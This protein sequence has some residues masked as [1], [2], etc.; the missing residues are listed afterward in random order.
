MYRMQRPLRTALAAIG[1]F[2]NAQ[3]GT[4]RASG[5]FVNAQNGTRRASGR[6]V[7]AQSVMR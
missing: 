7:K 4:R 1:R 2:V 5:R 6:S 3:N